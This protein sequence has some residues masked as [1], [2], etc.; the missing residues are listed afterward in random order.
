MGLLDGRDEGRERTGWHTR[1]GTDKLPDMKK[2]KSVTSGGLRGACIASLAVSV[3]CGCGGGSHF[4]A[5]D[6]LEVEVRPVT[7]YS[8]TLDASA[9]P[10]E[11]AF[12]AL[13]AVRDDFEAT[14]REARTRAIASQFDL[15]AINVLAGRNRTRLDDHEFVYDVVY[16][17][18][19][20]VSHYSG[21]FPKTAEEARSRFVRRLESD[22]QVE[23]A[24]VVADPEDDPRAQVVMAVWLARD[25][26]IW[27]VLHFGFDRKRSLGVAQGL[28]PARASGMSEEA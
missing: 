6:V 27:R 16:H 17:W 5:R 7:L 28:G 14:S 19:P 11:V 25:K 4:D 26:G 23:L 1:R 3:G 20:T 10:E 24:M 13:S 18:T 21:D 22:G 12:A 8:M 9:S 15:A 2:S